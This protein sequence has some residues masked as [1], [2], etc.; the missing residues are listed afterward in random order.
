M[1]YFEW[2]LYDSIL[3]PHKALKMVPTHSKCAM[4]THSPVYQL[5]TQT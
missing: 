4:N 1:L 3:N 2:L 5:K